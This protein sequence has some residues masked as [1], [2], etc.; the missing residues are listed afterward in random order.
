MKRRH[1]AALPDHVGGTRDPRAGRGEA[2]DVPGERG[3]VVDGDEIGEPGVT[4]RDRVDGNHPQRRPAEPLAA[5]SLEVF[6]DPLG[7][8]RCDMSPRTLTTLTEVK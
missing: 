6:A 7:H 4:F 3:A 5:L 1:D 2:E 8:S